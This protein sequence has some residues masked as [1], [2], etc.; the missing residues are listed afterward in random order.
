MSGGAA[1][2]GSSSGTAGEAMAAAF[3]RLRS[4]DD[5]LGRLVR[6]ADER[7]A[8]ESPGAREEAARRGELGPHWQRAQVR[9]DAGL[10]TLEAVM[11]GADGSPEAVAI[12]QA[13]RAQLQAST[14]AGPDDE[15]TRL[16]DEVGALQETL[17]AAA[18]RLRPDGGR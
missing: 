9:I 7:S 4:L 12:R 2:G 16:R 15:L 14:T 10:T 8:R 11:G 18:R 3:A 6:A 5:E 1:P 13:A 17:T